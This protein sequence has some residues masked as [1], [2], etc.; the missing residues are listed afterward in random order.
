MTLPSPYSLEGP[1][2]PAGFSPDPRPGHE[3][4]VVII[5]SARCASL[6]FDGTGEVLGYPARY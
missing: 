4:E 1:A 2:Y 5:C 6:E 3:D